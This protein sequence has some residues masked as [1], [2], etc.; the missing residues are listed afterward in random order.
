MTIIVIMSHWMKLMTRVFCSH[1]TSLYRIQVLQAVDWERT[2]KSFLV[3]FSLSTKCKESR[4]SWRVDHTWV[5]CSQQALVCRLLRTIL[6][7]GMSDTGKGICRFFSILSFLLLRRFRFSMMGVHSIF[8]TNFTSSFFPDRRTLKS[9]KWN[10]IQQIRN[11][12]LTAEHQLQC[13][14]VTAFN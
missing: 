1:S 6:V 4:Y 5:H 7:S 13:Y 12:G 2:L 3:L 8:E 11:C 9:L 10:V 14:R